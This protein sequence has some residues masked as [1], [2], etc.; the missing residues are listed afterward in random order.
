MK[1]FL[2]L[3]NVF[4]F[5]FFSCVQQDSTDIFALLVKLRCFLVLK[6]TPQEHYKEQMRHTGQDKTCF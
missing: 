2:K 4:V 3:I 6:H 5:C 1:H